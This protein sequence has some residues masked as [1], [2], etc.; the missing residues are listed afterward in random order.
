[1][2]CLDS[3]S[4]F[5]IEQL[6]LPVK[7]V[8]GELDRTEFFSSGSIMEVMV[9]T[10]HP[11]M[12]GMPERANITVTNSPVFTTT[13]GFEGSALAKYQD[14]GSP[15][16]S[17]FLL[18]EEHLNG[19]AAALDVKFGEGSVIL[20]GFRPQWRGQPFG[21]FRALFNAVLLSGE[22]AAGATGADGFWT[23]PVEDS[24]EEAEGEER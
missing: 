12:A 22:R 4:L 15:L 24:E 8:V 23:P 17:G 13:E 19:Y 16:M 9:N 18:G 3:S 7:D 2:I 1:M 14:A 21:T 5:A 6:H 11:V 10:R 20:F